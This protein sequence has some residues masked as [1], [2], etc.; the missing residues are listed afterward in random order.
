MT[1]LTVEVDGM[2]YSGDFSFSAPLGVR[3]IYKR[4]TAT[5]KLPGVTKTSAFNP[6]W[7]TCYHGNPT[8]PY[9]VCHRANHVVQIK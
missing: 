9:R 2:K 1:H 6:S 7:Y 5:E 8:A 3:F 4:F